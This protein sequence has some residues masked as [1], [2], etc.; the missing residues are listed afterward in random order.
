MRRVLPFLAAAVAGLAGPAAAHPH[1]FVD[2]IAGFRFD[3]DG[4]LA[5]LR[6]TWTYDAFTSLVMFDQLALDP[7]GDG[8]L[9]DADRAAIVAGETEWPPDYNGD[10]HLD[11]GGA[12]VAMGRPRDGAAWMENDRVTV[13]FDLPL[14]APRVLSDG[15]RLR[16]Y[17]PFYYYAYDVVGAETAEGA[18]CMARID[19]FE[20]DAASRM[21]QFQLFDLGREEIPAQEDVG[22]L[23]ADEV[24]L[25]CG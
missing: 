18:P 8:R 12:P 4:R 23:F 25:T 11:D 24:H 1:I 21:V 5:S 15:L 13:T 17:D 3:D 2:A 16:L 6:I 9:D 10:V 14:A 22:A 19:P 7:D 20:V